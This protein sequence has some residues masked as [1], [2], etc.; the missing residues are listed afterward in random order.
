MLD[1]GNP[2]VVVGIGEVLWDCLP[3]GKNLGGAPFNFC[4]Y[5]TLCGLDAVPVSAV[6][7]DADGDAIREVMTRENLSHRWISTVPELPT[8]LV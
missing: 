7:A 1:E 8:G 2:K 6:G 3:T 4:R 5:A